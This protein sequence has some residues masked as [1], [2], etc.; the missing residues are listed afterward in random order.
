MDKELVDLECR[1]NFFNAFKDTYKDIFRNTKLNT[2]LLPMKGDP[3]ASY[4]Y[5]LFSKDSKGCFLTSSKD[6]PL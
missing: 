6:W 2:I 1:L 3:N 5:S 4:E